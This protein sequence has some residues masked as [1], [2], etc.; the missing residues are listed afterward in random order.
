MSIWTYTTGEATDSGVVI[1]GD[2]PTDTRTIEKGMEALHV[3]LIPAILSDISTSR[4]KRYGSITTFLGPMFAGKS[5][6]LY[7]ASNKWGAPIVKSTR[8]TGKDALLKTHDGVGSSNIFFTDSLTIGDDLMELYGRVLASG[9]LCLDEYQM[10][11][12]YQVQ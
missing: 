5:T 2:S 6:K 11:E 10:L 4:V 1:C 3:G 7:A 12:N 8:Y 9:V